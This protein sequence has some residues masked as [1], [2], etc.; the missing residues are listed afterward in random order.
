MKIDTY[1]YGLGENSVLIVNRAIVNGLRDAGLLRFDRTPPLNPGVDWA[2]VGRMRDQVEPGA[3]VAVCQAAITLEVI[4]KIKEKSP[5]TLI[6]LQRDSSHARV[7]RDLVRAEMDKFNI[8]WSV[9]EESQLWRE[10]EEYR[11]ADVITVLSSWVEKSFHDQGF[12]DK[13]LYVGPQTFDRNRWSKAPL[14]EGKIFKVLFAGQTGLRKGLFY[15]LDAWKR[16]GLPNAQLLIAG[17]P[18]PSCDALVKEV[19]RRI[20]DTPAVIDLKYVPLSKMRD[21]YAACHVL[22]I[23]SIEEGAS[24][25]TFE[26]MSVGRPVIASTHTGADI[27]QH[28]VNGF[29]V[30]PGKWEDI[31]D[32]IF[33]YWKNRDGW[34]AHANEAA[35]S[36][37]GCDVPEF[38][39]R[40]SSKLMEVFN[41]H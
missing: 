27:L 34:I 19:E 37:G 13:V 31:A 8:H 40:Y 10:E 17:L 16:L 7:W 26:A 28:G 2:G 20:H 33:W 6:V 32:S 38:G 15:L 30:E 35:K 29:L 14:P 24:M 41:G 39:K 1:T 22:C 9:Y 18:E 5:S 36:V 4:Q 23:P 11:Q 12:G 25:T 3:D 21:T